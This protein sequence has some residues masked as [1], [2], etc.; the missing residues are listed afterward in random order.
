M[1]AISLE[2]KR[3]SGLS[4]LLLCFIRSEIAAE[5]TVSDSD[6]DLDSRSLSDPVDPSF[7]VGEGRARGKPQPSLKLESC[8]LRIFKD[9]KSC[10]VIPAR[11]S[12]WAV[13]LAYLGARDYVAA[14]L[15]AELSSRSGRR[16]SASP[17]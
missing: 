5:P 15:P 6:S 7:D 13:T 12:V 3:S 14:E 4:I 10:L 11:S 8:R 1:T 9:V 16:K 2:S 17:G